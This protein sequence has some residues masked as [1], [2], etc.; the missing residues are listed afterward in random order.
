[1]N[2]FD[3]VVLVLIAVAA[4]PVD[5]GWA[6]VLWVAVM[7]AIAFALRRGSR[8]RADAIVRAELVARRRD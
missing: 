5:R 7:L 6:A 1:M 4:V 8:Q 3:V 2:P